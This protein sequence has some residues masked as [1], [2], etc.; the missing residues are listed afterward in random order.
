MPRFT[1]QRARVCAEIALGP[2]EAVKAS[3]MRVRAELSAARVAETE[4]G[5]QP[6]PESSRVR[7]E[8]VIEPGA[9][10]R[11]ALEGIAEARDMERRTRAE[12]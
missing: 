2:S 9:G 10:R 8:M 4:L 6:L 12:R 3:K 1:L 11:S 5:A 7:L